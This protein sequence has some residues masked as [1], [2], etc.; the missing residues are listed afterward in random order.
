[1]IPADLRGGSRLSRLVIGQKYL[2]ADNEGQCTPMKDPWRLFVPPA[3]SRLA[4]TIRW[5]VRSVANPDLP[6]DFEQRT[7]QISG[8]F[9]T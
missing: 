3:S 1:M 9:G 4:V 2:E 8:V 5:W 7:A 6:W